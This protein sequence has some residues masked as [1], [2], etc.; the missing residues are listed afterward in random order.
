MKKGRSSN[1]WYEGAPHIKVE[2]RYKAQIMMWI[3]KKMNTEH[4]KNR[5]RKAKKMHKKR[6]HDL[7][8]L[9]GMDEENKRNDGRKFYTLACRMMTSFQPR[10]SIGRTGII[11]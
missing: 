2:E 8:V 6:V 4:Y 5:R 1:D 11:I 3:R 10:I 9:K 7:T